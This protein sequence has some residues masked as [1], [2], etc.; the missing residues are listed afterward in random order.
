MH[1]SQQDFPSGWLRCFL[2]CHFRCYLFCLQSS[3]QPGFTANPSMLPSPRVW[4][5]ISANQNYFPKFT[6]QRNTV[7]R[8]PDG[9]H[10]IFKISVAKWLTLCSMQRVRWGWQIHRGLGFSRVE[11]LF[12]FKH[13]NKL[14]EVIA[15][16]LNCI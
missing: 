14:S 9:L 15:H 8:R 16:A 1:S 10:K 5:S 4:A 11:H 3:V 13:M 2:I 6:G 12:K 7:N